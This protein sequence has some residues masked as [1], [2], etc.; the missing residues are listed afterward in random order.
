M[1]NT[2]SG[3]GAKNG[4]HMVPVK[5]TQL[6][7]KIE[8]KEG[9]DWLVFSNSI[10]TD[11]TM[12]DSVA[13]KFADRFRVLRYDTRGHG[14][15]K[16]IDDATA[17]ATKFEDLASDVVTILD[18]FGIGKCDF[19]GVSLGGITALGLG[20][21][22]PSRLR[23][24]TIIGSRADMPPPMIQAWTDR[25]ANA[26]KNGMQ[27]ELEPTLARWFTPEFRTAKP[28]VVDPIG[29]MILTTHPN[30]FA[31]GAS[32]LRVLAYLPKL[33]AIK[34]PT[35][36]IAGKQDGPTPAAM[37]GMSEVLPNVRF[38]EIDGAAHLVPVEQPDQTF[39]LIDAFLRERK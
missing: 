34:V 14:R 20:F 3:A 22:A 10:A 21:I 4:E 11:L 37:K 24:I 12:W 19:I 38:H 36:L 33:G 31:A 35:L 18:H 5:G 17:D 29:K 8:G 16:P 25:I 6:R 9:A 39:K 26:R 2:A 28:Q 27:A 30:G 7:V 1:S 32:A 23:S 15:S 13:P